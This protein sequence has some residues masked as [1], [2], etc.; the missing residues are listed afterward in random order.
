MND[1]MSWT[2]ES[3]EQTAAMMTRRL[4]ADF[5][6]QRLSFDEAMAR[7][8]RID[9][10]VMDRRETAGLAPQ[11]PALLTSILEMSAPDTLQ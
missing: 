10:W 4:T 6:H 7:A 9:Q 3:I 2:E 8:A 1:M 11:L 5:L